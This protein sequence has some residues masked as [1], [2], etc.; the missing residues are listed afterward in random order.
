LLIKWEAGLPKSFVI[1]FSCSSS[2]EEG[3]KGFLIS[4]SAKI[5]P[6][7]QT[8]IAAVYFFHERM[9][10]GARYHRVAM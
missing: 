3:S 6:T 1:M 10:S 8:S 5:H 4:N 2:E 9:T 7:D